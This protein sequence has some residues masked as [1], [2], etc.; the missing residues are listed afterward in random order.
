[1]KR[2]S[3]TK[4]LAS[5]V[6]LLHVA[7]YGM[8]SAVA[9]PGTLATAPLFLNTAVSPNIFFM[10]DDSGSMNWEVMTKDFSNN[11]IFDSTQ[12]DGTSPA[13]AGAATQRDDNDDGVADC[14]FNSGTFGG[15]VYGVVFPTN[16]YPDT[17][18]HC[19]TADDQAWR[20]RDSDFN[21]LYF[22]PNTTYTPWDGVDHNGVPFGNID[23][24]NAPD[25]PYNPQYYIDLTTA[26]SK[27]TTSDRDGD[28]VADG[29]SYYTWFD[30]NGNGQFD[31]GEEKEHLIKNEDAAT[32]QNFANWFSYYRSRDFVMK[33]ALSK[34]I[35]NTNGVRMGYGTIN[36]N[37]NVN[38]PIA[39]M[40]ADPTAGNK[41]ALLDKVFQTVPSGGTPLRQNLNLVG[42]YYESGTA[43]NTLFS[44][45]QAS[46][47]LSAAN[48]GTCELNFAV[49]MTDGFYNGASPGVGNTDGDGN[50]AYDG[51]PYGDTYSNTLADVAMHYYERDLRADLAN[52]V[53]TVPG[54][55]NATF[56]HMNTYTVALGVTGTL[57]PTT[58][59][60]TSA[61]FS[62]PDPSLSDAA[63]IDDLW[64]AAYNGR[65][66]FFSAQN[67]EELITTM[68]NTV[69]SIA[70]RT[71]S[72]SAVAFNSTNLGTDSYVY[73]ARFDT[74]QWSG[75]L[76][77]YALDPNN[78]TVAANPT[79]NAATVLDAR[80]LAGDPRTILTYDSGAK[81]GVP[82]QWADITA[83]EQNDLKT[84][85][86]GG[87]DAD[88]VG[89][90]R[91]N[92]IRGDRSNEAAGNLRIRASR[93]GDIVQSNPVYVG[94]PQLG[95]P[96]TAP[97]P[98]AVG[99]TYSD[100]KAA[101]ANRAGVIYVGGNDGMLH[102]FAS[103]NGAEVLGY[104]PSNLFTTASEQ[105]LHYLTDPNYAHRYYVDLSPTVSDVYI[106]TTPAGAVHWATVLVGGERGG[107]RGLFALD[108]TDPSAF[109]ETTPAPDN[110]V[111]WEFTSN[112]DADLGYTFS[113]PTI[114][115]TNVVDASGNHRWA[116]IFGNGYNDTGA[117]QAQLFI[118]FL[119]GGLDGVWTLGTD[120]IKINTG[121]GSAAATNGLATPNLMDLDHN[122][123]V[124]RVYAGDLQGNIWAFDLS[125][126]ASA[127]NWGVAYKQAATPKP[128]FTAKDSLGNVQPITSKPTAIIHPTE[129]TSSS[130]SNLPNLMVYFGT[131]Q[132]LVNGDKTTTG[133]QTF[134]GVWD[135]GTKSL[136]RANLVQQTFVS[137]YP[138]NVRVPTENNVDYSSKFGWYI[139]LPTSGERVV[140]SAKV[141]GDLVFFNTLIPSSQACSFGGSGWLMSV[142][143]VDGGPP[144]SPAIDINGDLVVDDNDKVINGTTGAT[145]AP[146]GQ[147][148]NEG[149][150]AESNFLGDHQY[151]PGSSGQIQHDVID[152]G[153]SANTGRLSWREIRF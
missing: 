139:D 137:G 18:K 15:Y 89:Q 23:I 50:T 103:S 4:P 47:I 10:I 62:W 133:T 140:T 29:F 60:P 92:F 80:N 6:I 132:Y 106:K 72:A 69:Q 135:S 118:V 55:D 57:D 39:D 86:A 153:S 85:P 104:I 53:P 108:V 93:M 56:Q 134:Y 87:T 102:G 36:Q 42:T 151:T 13:S 109:S 107:G 110:T 148:F 90:N 19:N 88:A 79:W 20:F 33:R 143:Q 82:F 100:Y 31:N 38:I 129:A 9:A 74:A 30:F 67:P 115:M 25:N 97:F 24:H 5:I 37:N 14:T 26:N 34:I 99:E 116:A 17:N 127:A 16:S 59:D 124:D 45:A 91:L 46:P 147:Q 119:D 76:L 44:S 141:R 54:V 145:A 58:A 49:L 122:G 152:V 125:N 105:G 8:P 126:T 21:P 65:G 64:H 75:E 112:D 41:R 111:M 130:P 101:Q 68:D 22:N 77:A 27:R 48:G 51:A 84:N 40:N 2:M 1:M 83:A 43:A 136:T 28:G 138:A 144:D 35:A 120:Y 98:S 81:A 7:T 123:T 94:V 63:K 70:D 73:Q 146:A 66:G 128:L 149:I 121:V 11:G 32:Q 142:K 150:P 114:A 117:G 3:V 78:G 71:S 12:P 96:D 95:Y 52:A 131:G 61:G 113:Q